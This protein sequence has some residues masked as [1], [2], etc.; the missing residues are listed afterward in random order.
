MKF[1][2]IAHF[3]T[4]DRFMQLAHFPSIGRILTSLLMTDFCKSI[5]FIYLRDSLLRSEWHFVLEKREDGAASPPHPRAKRNQESMLFI[6]WSTL[7]HYCIMHLFLG[8]GI[9]NDRFM[10]L[11]HI[12]VFKRFLTSFGMTFH[13]R[14]GGRKGA[15]SPPPSSQ[16][17]S[18]NCHSEWSEVEWGISERQ[19]TLCHFYIMTHFI[20]VGSRNDT[21]WAWE[22]GWWRAAEPPFITLAL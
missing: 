17:D 11:S 21:Y 1:R 5:I 19:S 4:N 9:T 16:K 22:K 12:Q 18:L 15:A 7:F 3:V 14:E 6:L 8:V 10:L 2:E 13:L 20:G